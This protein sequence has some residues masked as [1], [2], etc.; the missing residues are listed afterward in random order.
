MNALHDKA[1]EYGYMTITP[2]YQIKISSTL[3]KQ[4]G[5][6]SIASNF[7]KFNDHSLKLP[8]RFLPD[9]EFLKYHN[10]GAL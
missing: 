1:F 3:A 9:P 5:N 6:P 2:E 8:T 7:I 10:Q 4:S